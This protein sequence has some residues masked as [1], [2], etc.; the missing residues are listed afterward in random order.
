MRAVVLWVVFS[1]VLGPLLAHA[2]SS[3]WLQDA[4][5]CQILDRAPHPTVALGFDYVSDADIDGFG[6][7]GLVEWDAHW[8]AAYFHDVLLGDIDIGF[9][10]RFRMLTYP[11]RL[12]LP[13]RL[14]ALAVDVGWTWRY[15]NDTALQ[16]RLQPGFYSNMERLE[17]DALFVPF[18]AVGVLRLL[19]SCSAMVGMRIRPGFE[20]VLMPVIGVAWEPV[21][22]VRVEAMLPDSRVEVFWTRDWSTH[23]R[24]AWAS[25]TYQLHEDGNFQRDA[26]TVEDYRAAVG[27]TRRITDELYVSGEVGTAF[28]RSIEF[29]GKGGPTQSVDIDPSP[30][31]R[32]ALAGPF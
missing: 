17:F 16:V 14:V 31:V 24:F 23:V 4:R 3:S 20:R 9:D 22:E 7:T 12:Q 10:G 27:A 21:P 1:V 26:I 5:P 18:S 28:G 19:D 29:R 6:R 32:I 25:E 8:A 2:Q 11:A 15:V 30:F 13:D